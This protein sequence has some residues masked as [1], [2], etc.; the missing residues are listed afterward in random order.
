MCKEHPE[1]MTDSKLDRLHLHGLSDLLS[2][3]ADYIEAHDKLVARLAELEPVAALDLAEETLEPR[4]A[5]DKCI[6][7]EIA[8]RYKALLNRMKEAKSS[9]GGDH[10]E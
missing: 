9:E 10:H 4:F 7:T 8:P 3:Y 6:R 1:T 5:L 2:V